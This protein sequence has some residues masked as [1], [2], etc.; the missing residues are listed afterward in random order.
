MKGMTI[1]N[2]VQLI[3]VMVM[4]YV[5]F[6]VMIMF[7]TSTPQVSKDSQNVPLIDQ[8]HREI[9]TGDTVSRWIDSCLNDTVIIREEGVFKTKQIDKYSC[10]YTLLYKT[11][12]NITIPCYGVQKCYMDL[13]Y[14]Y[15]IAKCK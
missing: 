10:R 4:A 3:L 12:L 9:C 14:G 13:E 1:E 15:D 7:F 11:G 5:I 2:V 6:S 8:R